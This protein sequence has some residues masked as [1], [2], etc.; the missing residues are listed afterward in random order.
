MRAVSRVLG[1]RPLPLLAIATLK[2]VVIAVFTYAILDSQAT[3]R[4]EA[5]KRFD[6]TATIS[7]ALTSSLFGSSQGTTAAAAA[8]QYGGTT[9]SQ[10]ALDAAAAQ[11]KSY[12]LILDSRGKVLAA[13]KNTPA[14]DRSPAYAAAKHIRL[15][16]A[17][18]SELSDILTSS[19]KPALEWAIPFTT[20]QGRRVQV[21][22]VDA[23]LISSFLGSYLARTKTS[24][25]SQAFILD[26]ANRVVGASAPGAAAGARPDAPG[27]LEA[28]RHGD[29]GSYRERDTHRYFTTAPVDGS[30]WRVVLSDPTSTLYPAL[31]GAKSWYLLAALAALVLVA[32]SSTFFLRRAF[33]NGARL[34]TTNRELVDLT[35]TLEERVAE[36][37]AAADERATELARSNAELEQFASVTSHDLQ[38]PLRKIRMFGDRLRERLGD[39]LPAEP[40][41]DLGRMQN[42]A[43]RM[44]RLINDLL[45]FSRVTSR[46]KNFEPVDLGKVTEEV[47]SDLEARV[48]ELD[49]KVDVSALPVIDADQTQMRQLIQNLLSNALKFHREEEPPRIRISGDIIPGGEAHSQW[50]TAAADRCVLKVEDN[51]IGFDE[52]YAERVFVAFQRLH[53]RSSYDGTGIGLSIARKIVWRHGGNITAESVP[54]EGSTFTV[55]LPVTH[56]NGKEP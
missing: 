40:A 19:G 28:A 37:T 14:F 27:L 5:E 20:A 1:P 38:E 48:I 43:E 21:T 9:I 25:K 42:A 31:A 41:E 32:T 23:A 16:L 4:H 45:D 15:A 50:E 22:S 52:K 18:Q 7:A 46:G 6:A 13:S 30:T 33:V 49:A 47:L 10:E 11:S 29:R 39:D 17:G 34:A 44:Q 35:A 55:T 2:L 53:G 36:R 51:G 54:G 26:S 8:K 56:R 24:A 12:L 3:S